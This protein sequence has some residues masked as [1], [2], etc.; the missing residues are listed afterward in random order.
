MPSPSGL[1]CP[2][3][4]KLE[5]CLAIWKKSVPLKPQ[6]QPTNW[7]QSHT[8]Q[9]AWRI[10]SPKWNWH[11]G[12]PSQ[13]SANLSSTCDLQTQIQ[14]LNVTALIFPQT[15][16]CHTAQAPIRKLAPV[17]V[18]TNKVNSGAENINI[19]GG[20]RTPISE[21]T[22]WDRPPASSHHSAAAWRRCREVPKNPRRALHL[23]GSEARFGGVG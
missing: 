13:P 10:A 8:T 21:V 6:H 11:C 9:G 20:G 4:V 18:T 5:I 17:D 7:N 19:L 2:S 16:S 3:R 23:W 1:H 14:G 15:Y 12:V 22:R